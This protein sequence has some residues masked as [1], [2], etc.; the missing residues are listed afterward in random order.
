MCMGNN[1][2]REGREGRTERGRSTLLWC[3]LLCAVLWDG[4]QHRKVEICVAVQFLITL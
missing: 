1:K 4:T 2:G 3:A